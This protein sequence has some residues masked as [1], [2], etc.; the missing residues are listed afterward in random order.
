ME[1][2]EA[3]WDV[4]LKAAANRL[5][6]D[7]RLRPFDEVVSCMSGV[8]EGT[9][10]NLDRDE[11][12]MPRIRACGASRRGRAEEAGGTQRRPCRGS[13]AVDPSRLPV[14]FELVSGTTCACGEGKVVGLAAANYMGLR[15][16]VK[17]PPCQARGLL[18]DGIRTD[19]P[20]SRAMGK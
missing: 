8:A 9:V 4:S 2:G 7:S 16:L 1:A 19:L 12:A 10:A 14:S 11:L 3:A 18:H 6:R 17:V 13:G 5:R 20:S 15:A